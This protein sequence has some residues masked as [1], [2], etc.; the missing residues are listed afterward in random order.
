M[1]SDLITVKKCC[2]L[3]KGVFV[4]REKSEL[5]LNNSRTDLFCI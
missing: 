1:D 3:M 5:D 2:L 4:H